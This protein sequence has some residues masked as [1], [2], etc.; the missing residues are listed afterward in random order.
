MKNNTTISQ[1]LMSNLVGMYALIW[2]EDDNDK[3]KAKAFIY[4]KADETYYIVQAINAMTGVPNVSK[5]MTIEQIK[6]W[7]FIPNQEI[8]NDILDDYDKH[9]KNRFNFSF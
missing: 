7:T 1:S 3:L 5:L 6:D 8:L 2:H 9:K 4:G